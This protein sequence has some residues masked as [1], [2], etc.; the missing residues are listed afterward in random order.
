[1]HNPRV[2]IAGK[3]LVP[4][5]RSTPAG[6][7]DTSSEE[8]VAFNAELLWIAIRETIRHAD[9]PAK[10][11]GMEGVPGWLWRGNPLTVAVALWDGMDQSDITTEVMAELY[12]YLRL[13]MHLLRTD[14]GSQGRQWWVA[15]E[16]DGTRQPSRP[17]WD[18]LTAPLPP[19]DIARLKEARDNGELPVRRL[20]PAPKMDPADALQAVLA[21]IHS[22]RADNQR[23]R[24]TVSAAGDQSELMEDILRL[25]G[26][27]SELQESN[28]ALRAYKAR[29]ETILG[30]DDSV[31]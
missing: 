20:V 1:M 9:K 31:S 18:A 23:L 21:E 4:D 5:A 17:Y 7:P 12:D 26:Q 11:E 2:T 25:R 27:L 6:R 22:L 28:R 15:D 30:Q 13:T 14:E 8:Q 16:W 24:A 19:E 3:D 29:A 10:P